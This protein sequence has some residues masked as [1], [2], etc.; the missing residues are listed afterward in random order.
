MDPSVARALR[1]KALVE[2]RNTATGAVE[3]TTTEFQYRFGPESSLIA[4][5]KKCLAY[6]KDWLA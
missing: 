4:E 5:M 3:R 1:F 2:L 6:C